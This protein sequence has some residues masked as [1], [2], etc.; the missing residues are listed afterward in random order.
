MKIGKKYNLVCGISRMA[1]ALG[2][3]PNEVNSSLRV[4]I[5]C[6]APESARQTLN[7]GTPMLK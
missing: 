5:P 3:G 4:Q 7:G 6:P 2:L 1:Q